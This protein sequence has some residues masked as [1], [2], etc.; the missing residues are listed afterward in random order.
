M[1]KSMT[2]YGRSIAQTE[3]WKATVEIKSVN[4]RFLDI[5]IKMPKQYMSLEENIKKE[6][7]SVLS[8]E[9]SMF[10]SR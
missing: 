4:N 10:S 8:R 9:E 7:S 1:V 3:Q 6:I 5:I 2:G